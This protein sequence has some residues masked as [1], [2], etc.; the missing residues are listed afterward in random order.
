MVALESTALS[1][2]KTIVQKAAGAWIADRRTAEVAKKELME[3]LTPWFR[4]ES[5]EQ[6]FL[7]VAALTQSRHNGAEVAARKS[8]LGVRLGRLRLLPHYFK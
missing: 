7:D 3:L 8:A 4:R 5:P 1:L 6:R 2:A